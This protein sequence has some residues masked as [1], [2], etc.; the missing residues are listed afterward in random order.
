M[1]RIIL[2][3]AVVATTFSFAQKK[4]I[5]A[6]YK[7][8][9]S[10]D[11]SG[12]NAQISA[13]EAAMQGKI[14]LLEPETLEQY[15]FTKGLIA[16]KSGKVSEGAPYL[17]KIAD[18]GKTDIYTG[19]DA[20]KNKV[21]Y[22]GK[23]AADASGIS[24]LKAEKYTPSTTAKLTEAINPTLTKVRN[25]A[26]E[27][28]NNKKYEAAAPKF[29]ESYNLSKALGDDNKML[30]YYAGIAYSTYNKD[31]AIEIYKSL[32][33]SGYTGVEKS[34]T[35]KNKKTGEVQTL[36]KA[37]WDVYQKMGEASEYSDFKTDT[38]KS[39]EAD[40]YEYTAALLIEAEK[41]DDA[42]AMIDK[43]LKKFPNNSKLSE[44]QGIAYHKSGKTGEFVESLKAQLAKN[45]NDKINWFNL[46][47]LL[48]KDEATKDE[49]LA[50][51]DKVIQL[52]PKYTNAYI[53]AAYLL[54]GD[55]SKSID[56]YNAL[57]KAGKMDE[58]NKVLEERRARFAKAIPYVEKWHNAEPNEIEAVSLLK[59]LYTSTKNDAKAA[60]YKAKEAE[61][62]AAQGK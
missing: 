36:D 5:S 12:A 2:A 35:A 27:A 49:A 57:R 43:G 34:Y 41:Y 60:E 19:K 39:V 48:G 38:S 30:L 50:A 26:V 20:S 32:L 7:A 44:L 28:F 25:E 3:A 18:L 62:K 10:N 14:Y 46:A 37:T 53:N 40:L 6:A 45:P 15:Y 54:M 13:A 55:D 16:I 42:L 52:D 4:E 23:E 47:V 8:I 51:Y 56:S 22:V 58:A 11:I 17:A 24:G 59:S 29:E 21:Y 31:K 61:M 1:K 9:G 33:D